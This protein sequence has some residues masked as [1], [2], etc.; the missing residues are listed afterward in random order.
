[1]P[2]LTLFAVGSAVAAD[3]PDSRYRSGPDVYYGAP[4]VHGRTVCVEEE[5][6]LLFTPMN[7][8]IPYIPP[9]IR[10]PLLPGSSTCPAITV[11][12]IP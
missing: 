6:D 9:L 5:R 2:F 1:M 8:A 3:L 11:R 7:G 4:P 12:R 10:A